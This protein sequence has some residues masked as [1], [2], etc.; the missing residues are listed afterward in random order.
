MLRPVEMRKF[1]I[2]VPHQYELELVHTLAALGTHVASRGGVEEP[3]VA[4]LAGIVRKKELERGDLERALKLLEVSAGVEGEYYRVARAIVEE[5]SQLERLEKYVSRLAE[6]GVSVEQLRGEGLVFVTA[7]PLGAGEASK[8]AA[9]VEGEGVHAMSVRVGDETMLIVV[10]LSEKRDAVLSILRDMG[11]K[12]LEVPDWLGPSLNAGLKMV[13]E[14]KRA[15]M[16]EF[17]NVISYYIRTRREGEGRELAMYDEYVEL[18][19]RISSMY[20]Q[21]E[22]VA[23]HV[24][25]EICLKPPRRRM[26][27]ER[28]HIERAL[29]EIRERVDKLS[30]QV[31]AL[32]ERMIELKTLTEEL[33]QLK[34]LSRYLAKL[35]ELG[36]SLDQLR[37]RGLIFVEAVPLKPEEVGEVSSAIE[38]EGVHVVPVEANGEES[39]LVIVGISEKRE[40]VLSILSE[41]GLKPLEVPDW[42]GPSLNA[43]LKMVEERRK[44]LARRLEAVSRAVKRRAEE[45]GYELANLLST[46]RA[47]ERCM[48][49]LVIARSVVRRLRILRRHEYSIVEGWIPATY[50]DELKRAVEERVPVLLVEIV[51]LKKGEEAPY[52][53]RLRG[54]LSHFTALTLALG[55]P[56]YWEL[57][58][59]IILAVL[60]TLMYGMMFGDLGLG[61]ILI[62]MSFIVKRWKSFGEFLG[63]TPSGLDT[64]S[65]LMKACGASSTAFG[66]VYGIAFLVKI[67]ESPF[68]PLHDI[69]RI[70]AVA[71]FFGILQLILGMLLNIINSL[72][73]GDLYDAVLGSRGL[74]GLIFY[75]S[76]LLLAFTVVR[77]G[78]SL[79][80]VMEWPHV[81]F[82]YVL[83]ATL[84]GVMLAPLYRYLTEGL[85]PGEC[86]AEGFTSAL[87]MLMG[88][89][90][91]T[92]S[93]VRLAAF[94]IAH[95][96]F[97]L[98]AFALAPT[99]GQIPSLLLA[100]ALVLILEGFAVG[101]Q[102][103]RLIFYE[104]STK[105]FRGGGIAFR[106]LSIEVEAGER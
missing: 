2:L 71:I 83:L 13:E 95:E 64:L 85:S 86:L 32:S 22:E 73:I 53:S 93:Y 30:P 99:L 88:L 106:P 17:R 79:G 14:R 101:I 62:L 19:E 65:T 47:M 49:A 16:Q 3:I 76:G 48:N 39:L 103:A 54:L 104:F 84:V 27:C 43:G 77:K 35:A 34:R 58:P 91:N 87:E 21:L 25:G 29:K 60:F 33:A 9:A 38:R 28:R 80:A 56:S 5:I 45:L 15:L 81:L 55:V 68:S 1:R 12:P 24:G 6:L 97:G 96:A 105:F 57:D 78:L 69:V 98:M 36:V 18:S 63:L 31:K 72:M 61:P 100:N 75:I 52:L 37:G 74:L 51:E 44:I 67:Y 102:A 46:V 70:V 11:L 7:V 90:A 82:L 20:S 66:A 23:R 50:S 26:M 8:V 42:L 89:P 40:E 59:T 92:L 94:A 10:G 4:E 41:M